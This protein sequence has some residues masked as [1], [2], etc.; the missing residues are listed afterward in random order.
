[1][2]CSEARALAI[3]YLEAAAA[4]REAEPP[5][6]M[7]GHIAS[8]PHCL[9]DLTVLGSATT[10]QPS[11]LLLMIYQHSGCDLVARLMPS[12]VRSDI[13]GANLAETYPV[14]WSHLQGCQRCQED[15][16]ELRELV[17]AAQHGEYGLPPG[18]TG[19]EVKAL[20]LNQEPLRSDIANDV[21][22]TT[23]RALGEGPVLLNPRRGE[24][25]WTVP[26][27]AESTHQR[28]GKS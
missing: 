7:L 6:G 19:F 9:E 5:A 14:A 20:D 4:N 11:P 25:T 8:C 17:L 15:F 18:T 24:K 22:E 1:M 23:L 3:R 13:E 16:S 21:A 27:P 10:G 28:G 12:W 26:L 2:K